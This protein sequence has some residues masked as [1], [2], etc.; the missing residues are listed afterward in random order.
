MNAGNTIKKNE[1]LLDSQNDVYKFTSNG[2]TEITFSISNE[3][4]STS[5]LFI[6]LI[7][8][9]VI[10]IVAIIVVGIIKFGIES[11]SDY[12]NVGSIGV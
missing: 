6:V 4:I 7:V 8:I 2:P 9:I 1:I 5:S 12:L 3:I 11:Q 10:V